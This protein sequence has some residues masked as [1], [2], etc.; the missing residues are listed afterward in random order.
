MDLN[1]E[2][3]LNLNNNINYNLNN[4]LLKEQKTHSQLKQYY[5]EL[6]IL[7]SN[8]PINSREKSELTQFKNK[9]I[10][11]VKNIFEDKYDLFCSIG[12]AI[13]LQLFLEYLGQLL[14]RNIAKIIEGYKL[15]E[16]SDNSQ[17]LLVSKTKGTIISFLI[18][19]FDFYEDELVINNEEIV[20]QIID[21]RDNLED[22]FIITLIKT[23]NLLNMPYIT[24][25]E[26]INMFKQDKKSKI[27]SFKSK[28]LGYHF[29][30]I[31]ELFFK[32]RSLNSTM[33]INKTRNSIRN[34]K[35]FENNRTNEDIKKSSL[36]K[37][38]IQF[39]TF[40]GICFEKILPSII[41]IFS[42]VF[43]EYDINNTINIIIKKGELNSLFNNFN[44]V[45]IIRNKIF[46]I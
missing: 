28:D 21:N 1:E 39:S 14:Q 45:K 27:F 20:A 35:N 9:I 44:H 46:N 24:K 40:L 25:Y 8:R 11:L 15:F 38:D 33:S 23:I 32:I 6:K 43:L 37:G 42:N 13:D 29:L 5:K 2:L 10:D 18:S 4:Q 31:I 30:K 41:E 26:F 12:T 7:T 17:L 3:N 34:S 22:S 36:T 16:K 19:F